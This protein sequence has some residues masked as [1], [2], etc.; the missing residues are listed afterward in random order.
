MALITVS[1]VITTAFNRAVNTKQIKDSDIEACEFNYIRPI[2]TENFYE[3]VR[4]N[5]GSYATLIDTYINPCLSYYVK[6][7]T[8]NDFLIE[9]SDRGINQLVSENA[10]PVSNQTRTDGKADV[11]L[12]AEIMGEKLLDYIKKRVLADDVLY[13]LYRDFSNVSPE[14]KIIGGM[15]IDDNTYYLSKENEEF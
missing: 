3:Y 11:L 10:N 1:D 8:Y 2:L 5:V 6:W 7:L 9:I 12:K 13:V 4:D 15:L 14:P